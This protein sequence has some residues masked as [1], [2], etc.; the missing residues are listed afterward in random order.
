MQDAPAKIN[1][2]LLITH[3]SADK[4]T[5]AGNSATFVKNAASKD[6]E[7]V[8]YKGYYHEMHN[9]NEREVVIEK[10]ISWIKQRISKK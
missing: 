5:S 3:G 6:K 9:D 4:I 2:P 1:I 8:E 7:F 10:Y